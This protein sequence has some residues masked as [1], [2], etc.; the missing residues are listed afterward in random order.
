MAACAWSTAL[1]LD[2]LH[3][4]SHFLLQTF[5]DERSEARKNATKEEKLKLREEKEALRQKYGYALMDG[6]K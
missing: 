3:Y 4:W 1:A 5:Y 2:Q 6:R